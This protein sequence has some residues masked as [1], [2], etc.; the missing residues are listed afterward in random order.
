MLSKRIPSILPSLT[1]DQ[2][3]STT[4]IHSIGGMLGPGEGLIVRPPLRSPHHTASDAALVG[5]GRIPGVGE[6]SLAHNGV[7][8]MDE[9]VE[10]R[11]NVLQALRQPLEDNE[12][13]VARASGS[14][15]FP[16]DFM[17][18]ASS[19][20][21]Q[22][23]F[24]FDEEIPCRCS[25]ERAR[26][27]F[28]KIAGPILDRIDIEVLVNRVPCR[29][30]MS[31]GEGENSR[32]IRERVLKART[33]QRKR[34]QDSPT[35][36]NSRMTPEDIQR[37]CII[38]AET[39]KIMENA[40]KRLNLSARSFFRVLKVSRTIADLDESPNIRKNHLLEALTYK[41]L[42]RMYDTV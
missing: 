25:P 28:H 27:Y 39:E 35:V 33:L 21:C 37:H 31:A 11:N 12:I 6:I 36:Y 10:F 9:F 24:L 13:T 15:T 3:I 4:M 32:T 22:C 29:D 41:N 42:Q 2:A 7:L 17:L 16:A 19:N 1:R 30:L 14:F 8:L 26:H 5:G 23:G 34:F 20:P 40:L 38:D 18:V